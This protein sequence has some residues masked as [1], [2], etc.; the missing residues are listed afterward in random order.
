MNPRSHAAMRELLPSYAANQLNPG[1][2][3]A[4]ERHIATCA[5]CRAEVGEWL[6][7]GDWL[8]QD[9]AAI[10]PDT[11]AARGLAAIHAHLRQPP[12]YS[13]NGFD[14]FERS[15]L[16]T[17][18]EQDSPHNPIGQNDALTTPVLSERH[19]SAGPSYGAPSRTSQPP[20]RRISSVAAGASALVF[21]ALVAS[22]FYVLA[23]QVH[24][25]PI[26][27]A[28]T[29]TATTQLTPTPKPVSGSWHTAP[30]APTISSGVQFAKNAPQTGYLCAYVG[31]GSGSAPT[32][33]SKWLYKTTDGGMTWRP[34][35]GLTPPNLASTSC[36]VFIDANNA[37]DVF[38]QL[39]CDG[40]GSAPCAS[41]WRS[42]DGGATWRQL[43][44]P[45]LPWGWD[46][47]AVVGSRIIGLGT[48]DFPSRSPYGPMCT[49]DP[50]STDLHQLNDLFASDDDGKTWKQIGQPLI[51]Q[52]LSIVPGGDSGF[53]TAPSSSPALLSFGAALFVRTFCF[54][55]H[56]GDLRSQQTY[57]KSGDSGETWAK[58]SAPDS[59]MYLTPSATGG[60]YGVAVSPT[61]NS[62]LATT[63]V[64]LYSHD[65]GTSWSA[66]PSLDSIPLPPDIKKSAPGCVTTCYTHYGAPLAI[67]LPDGSVLVEFHVQD[68]R[69]NATLD[70]LYA[71][72][73]GSAQPA[74]RQFAPMNA[75]S[76]SITSL[77]GWPLAATS[78]GLVLWALPNNGQSPLT[79]VY[80]SPLP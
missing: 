27:L 73:P 36:Q 63:P 30:D 7:L 55:G 58:I 80:L 18:P 57:W 8:A 41:L 53:T 20:Q 66:L 59:D 79:R 70:A 1:E 56:S 12:A 2:R 64:I 28:P 65:S 31:V 21:L 10:P 75:G 74:W 48:D 39:V 72:D 51:A 9:D 24:R 42:P 54:A 77:T 4:V 35:G 67:A 50:N 29:P 32:S 49:T 19:T 46:N 68:T 22:L 78:Q 34:V 15:A 14:G 71:I 33:S 3:A 16:P 40:A 44:M 26:T 6:T 76:T 61:R 17:M 62:F 69:T 37:N 5:E 47:I 52:G 25:G 38:V 43:S 23:P 13:L 45:Q 60:A 11:G